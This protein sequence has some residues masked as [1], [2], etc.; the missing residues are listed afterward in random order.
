MDPKDLPKRTEPWPKDSPCSQCGKPVGEP[1]H[2]KALIPIRPLCYACAPP[3]YKALERAAKG[4]AEGGETLKSDYALAPTTKS[5]CPECHQLV[6]LL[7]LDSGTPTDGPAFFICFGCTWVG[8]VGKGPVVREYDS[9]A[10]VL[11]SR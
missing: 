3:W 10:G 2:P 8:E 4:E 5:R 11:A 1:W 9:P 7:C 6:H